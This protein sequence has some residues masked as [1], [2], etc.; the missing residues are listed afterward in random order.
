MKLN[1]TKNSTNSSISQ[2]IFSLFEFGKVESYQS[3]PPMFTL[4]LVAGSCLLYS[5]WTVVVK[6][7]HLTVTFVG[8]GTAV[9][10]IEDTN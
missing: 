2:V 5:Q 4:N 3:S 9:K 6:F 1:F 8:G 7:W 10:I